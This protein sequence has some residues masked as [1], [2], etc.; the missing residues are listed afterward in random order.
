VRNTSTTLKVKDNELIAIGGLLREEDR[1]L[2]KRIPILSSI[3]VIGRIFTATR[4]EK[5]RT[6]LVFFLRI[7]ILPESEA[8]AY[9]VPEQGL[10]DKRLDKTIDLMRGNVPESDQ[11]IAPTEA[12]DAVGG[13]SEGDVERSDVKVKVERSDDA[14]ADDDLSAAGAAPLPEDAPAP[15]PAPAAAEE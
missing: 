12:D 1:L 10:P 5:G 4:H 2:E 15:D 8:G 11:N 9:S 6:Q 7:Q 14:S 3:P 13:I